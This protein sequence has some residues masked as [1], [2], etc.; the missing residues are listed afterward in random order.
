MKNLGVIFKRE[1]GSYFSTPLAYIFIVIFLVLSAVFTFYLG[2]FY[3]SGQ[4]DLNA[5]FN[6]HPWLYLFL[7]PAVAMRL[8]AEERKSGTI[9]LLMTLPVSRSDMV[10]GKFLAAWVFIGIALLLTFPIIITVNY[11]GAPDNGAIFTGYL[12]SWLLAGGY[13]AIGSCMSALTK[14]QVI[15]FIVSVVA[16][17]IFIVSGFSLWLDLFTGW[18]PQWLLDAIAS[19]SF[20]IRFDAISKGVLD[21]R[22][23]LYFVSL[24]AVWLLATAIVI[25]LKK[26]D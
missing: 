26:A 21:L 1:L 7:V 13:L 12:G 14:N 8:W 17:F 10:L 5:F 19:L 4:A 22:D 2:G 18:A 16:C 25:D 24:M 9:E 15:A 20:L 3:E 23:L 6:F 11:L